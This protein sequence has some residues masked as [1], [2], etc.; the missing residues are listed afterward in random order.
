MS[1]APAPR[2][3]L[4]LRLLTAGVTAP[5][6]VYLLFAGPHWGFVALTA[7]VCALGAQELF[8]MVAPAHR[9]IR[10]WGIVATLGVFALVARI[11]D[12]AWSIAGQLL[13]VCG[14]MLV[15]LIKIEPMEQAALR[16]GWSIAGPLYL[17]ALFGLIGR[18]FLGPHGGEWTV[19]SM[20]F[21]F[22]S[23]TGGYF[24]GRA[25]GKHKLYEAV[26]PKKTIEGSIGGIG[27][28]LLGAMVAH[29]W[30]L[31]QLPLVHAIGLAIVSGAAGQAG[32]LCE[33]VVK[34]STG[35]KDSGTILPGHGGILDRVD[36]LL[37]STVVVWAYV[38]LMG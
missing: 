37:F 35:V 16:M 7:F 9:L 31:K 23:D 3:N 32:D 26:S 19:L 1:D 18:L 6:I 21:A 36:A 24:A 15:S 38:E 30:F 13:L 10:G 14:G 28:A 22:W 12:P 8:M 25:Y 5:V 11:V 27:G 34:R 2:S 33:S 20:L 29:F 17:G 4:T